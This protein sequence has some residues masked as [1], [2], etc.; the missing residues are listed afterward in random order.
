[1]PELNVNVIS[2]TEQCRSHTRGPKSRDVLAKLFPNLDVSNEALPF[3]GY[4]EGDLQGVSARI[5]RIS[6]SGELAYEINVESD[7]GLF[8]GKN[9]GNWKRI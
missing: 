6:F 1:M 7:Y 8:M 2:T 4:V 5:F 3:M 9:D